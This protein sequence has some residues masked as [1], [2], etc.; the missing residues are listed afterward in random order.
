MDLRG[1]LNDNAPAATTPSKPPPPPPMMPSTPVQTNPRQPFRDY[2]QTHPSPGRH[3][4]MDYSLQQAPPG[5]YASPP[6]YPSAGPY[7][8]RPAQPPP[9]QQISPHDLRSP[10]ITSGGPGPSPYRQTP[11]SSLSASS[12]AY[13]FPPQHPSTTSPVQQQRY[14]PQGPYHRDSFPQP[15][16]PGGMTG[17]PGGVSY[18]QAGPQVPQTPP[19]VTPGG[20]G[21]PHQRSQ[22]THSTSTPTS[23]HSQHA[24]YGAPFLQGSPV[25]AH[26]SLP[27]MEPPSRHSSQPP[28]PVA[29]PLNR[30]AQT[31]SFGQPPSPYQQRLPTATTYPPHPPSQTS[32]PQPHPPSLPRHSSS[33]TAAYDP[34]AHEAHRRSQSRGDRDRSLS[35]SP[36]TRVPSLPGSASRPGTSVSDHDPR[37]VSTHPSLTMPSAMDHERERAVTP[38]K[39]KLEDRE[40]RPDELEKREV[41][42][43]PFENT[44]GR[45]AQI[46]V[47]PLS[48]SHA[49]AFRKPLKKRTKYSNPP[50]WGLPLQ[51]R[52]PTHANITIYRP[53]QHAAQAVNGTPDGPSSRHTS[54]EERRAIPA[55]HTA[56]AAPPPQP[57]VPEPVP[58]V[59]AQ[60]PPW[61]PSITGVMPR[62][63]MS[64]VVAD[65]LF[66][67]VVLH[68]AM[69]EMQSRK[70]QFEIEAKL[71]TLIDKST[72]QRISLPCISECVLNDQGSWLGFRSSM[73]EVSLSR[74]GLCSA[75]CR[76]PSWPPQ[77]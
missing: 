37:R 62:D 67:Y 13:P 36:K 23:A 68:P 40:L 72:G 9:L 45:S 48:Q 34:V 53:P 4:S 28:T 24:Q 66:Q 17:P 41:R 18:M 31:M 63:A 26:H 32:P 56:A 49:N 7:P 50:V 46:D 20:H 64:K 10:S 12:G 1:I 52:R 8:T 11:T 29:A 14:P 61:E 75:H 38:A 74:P 55:P 73:S 70:V 15:S 47:A 51:G 77:R 3:M 58:P 27:H 43:P 42:P 6:A 25:A 22:S 19:V 60:I 39:R 69:G 21:Y 33:T 35:V 57:A 16:M 2:S 44:N 5:A 65:F 76:L 71:G 59:D 54:P 30:S